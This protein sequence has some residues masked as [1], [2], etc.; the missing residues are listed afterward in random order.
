MLT[1]AGVRD[2]LGEIETDIDVAALPA[3]EDLIDA[4]FDSLDLADL[5]LTLQER[6][7]L[8]VPDDDLEL[9]RSIQAIVEYAAKKEGA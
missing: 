6:H 3:G 5:L 7:G 1:E 4:G 9:V 2:A 8:V